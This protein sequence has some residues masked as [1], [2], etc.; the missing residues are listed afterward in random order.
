MKW[1]RVK[2]GL[3]M[4]TSV[5]LL[6][7]LVMWVV[8]SELLR[9]MDHYR[10]VFPG[11]VTGLFPGAEVNYRGVIVGK[12][13]QVSLTPDAPPRP[14]VLIALKRG[15]PVR[16]DTYARL[17]T[18]LVTNISHIELDGGSADRPPRAQMDI[19]PVKDK[20]LGK[21]QEQAAELAER[22]VQVVDRVQTEVLTPENLRAVAAMVQDL[23]AV[24]GALRLTVAE[25][26]T[27]QTRTALRTAIVEA[28]R[29]AT[30]A[31]QLAQGMQFLRE[32][33]KAVMADLRKTA[34]QTAALT[35]QV[36]QLVRR[37]DATVAGNQGE[38]GRLLENLQDTSTQLREVAGALRSDPSQLVW[39]SNLPAR[40][41]PD[42]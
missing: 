42:R 39:G 38:L 7:A 9:P 32:D 16:Q 34:A 4:V 36:S 5:G 27:P 10:V 29:T 19:I 13:Q 22:V 17:E 35:A 30:E 1:D 20:G 37:V 31:R 6:V 12:V 11:A 2:V 14:M 15:T 24:T 8:G 18:L 25:I 23:R 3:F 21:V 26:S 33:G 40:K 28:S 41:I